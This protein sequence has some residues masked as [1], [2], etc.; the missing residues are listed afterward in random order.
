MLVFI[1]HISLVNAVFNFL[2]YHCLYFI[3][4]TL[5]LKEYYTVIGPLLHILLTVPQ[6]HKRN[7][8]ITT[9]LYLE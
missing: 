2:H 7:L 6:S 1:N 3:C 9:R 8:I 5:S 4:S